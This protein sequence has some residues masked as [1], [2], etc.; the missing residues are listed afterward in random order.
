ME[1]FKRKRKKKKRKAKGNWEFSDL[2][3]AKEAI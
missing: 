1:K 3:N 2:L